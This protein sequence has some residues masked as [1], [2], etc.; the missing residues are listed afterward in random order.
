[1]SDFM[2][3]VGQVDMD[4]YKLLAVAMIQQGLDDLRYQRYSPKRTWD[5]EKMQIFEDSAL[6]VYAEEGDRP[7]SFPWCAG[8]L[9]LPISVLRKGIA[10]RLPPDSR[11]HLDPIL[12]TIEK[13]RNGTTN[14]LASA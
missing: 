3:L 1:M 4:P 9:G 10:D 5:E 2:D 7:G 13:E 8:I 12:V 11:A 6:W 14:L